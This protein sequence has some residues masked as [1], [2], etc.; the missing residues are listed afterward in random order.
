MLLSEFNQIKEAWLTH[1]FDQVSKKTKE[2][3]RQ[4]DLRSRVEI[5]VIEHKIRMRDL[6]LF[7]PFLLAESDDVL[8]LK[9]NIIYYEDFC[10]KGEFDGYGKMTFYT[11]DPNGKIVVSME[12]G[13][14]LRILDCFGKLITLNNS[15]KEKYTRNRE[16][17]LKTER[18]DQIR[19]S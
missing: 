10:L 18:L 9:D 4:E 7:I 2:S 5:N 6:G 13:D 15:E 17:Y 3:I 14:R 1:V 8:I 16:L 19:I 12:Y 11:R